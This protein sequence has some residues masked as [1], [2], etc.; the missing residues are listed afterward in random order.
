MAALVLAVHLATNGLYDFHRDSLYYLDSARHPA[1]GYVDYP[2]VTPAIARFSLWVF[3]PSVWGLRLWP[4]IAGAVMVVLAALIARELGGGRTARLLAALGAATSLVLL[5]ANWLF[6]T[7]TFDELVWLTTLLIAARLLRTGDRRLWIAL[8]LAI[9]IGLETK[10]TVIGLIVGMVVGTLA[11]KLRHDLATPWPWFAVALSLLIFLPNLLWQA[12]NDWPS[13][14]YTFNHKSTQSV[15]FSPLTFLV[16]QLALIGPVAIPIWIAGLYWLLVSPAR[17]MLG[18][19]AA[20]AFVLY[21][22][23]G[24]SYYVGPLHPFLLAAGACA[25]ESWTLRRRPW[26]RPMVAAALTLQAL[27]LLPLALP[28]LPEPLM[29]RSFL[30]QARTDFAA[31]VG[32]H[33]LVAQVDTIYR[34]LSPQ[35]QATA[36]ILAN[37]YGEAGAINTYGHPMGL[38]EAVSGELSYYYWKPS[39]LD[40]PVITIGL[41]PAFLLTL[42]NRCDPAG[43]VSNSYQLNNEEYGAPLMVCRLPKLPLDQ[44]WP[45]LK[46]FR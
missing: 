16:Q 37:N 25:V 9:G 40:G 18:I 38:P 41:D 44:L 42:F 31:T 5:G 27:V 32:W 29:A 10:Y 12:G 28:V 14:Q 23:V 3:G 39:S 36:V 45:R 46:A 33:D 24:K 4:S 21:L 17:R 11:T 6:Q 13:V 34:G 19:A 15:D 7:V 1:W 30:A 8:G 43:T 35:D 22:F 26:V 20:T 2:P